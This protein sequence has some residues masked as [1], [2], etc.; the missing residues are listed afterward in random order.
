MFEGRRGHFVIPV[1]DENK[2]FLINK[3][4]RCLSL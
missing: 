1:I 3:E 4:V 2:A